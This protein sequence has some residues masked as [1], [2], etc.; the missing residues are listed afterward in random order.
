MDEWMDRQMDQTDGHRGR[1]IW[2]YILSFIKYLIGIF[3][4]LRKIPST[5]V[6]KKLYF[7]GSFFWWEGKEILTKGLLMVEMWKRKAGSWI[8]LLVST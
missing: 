5:N 8:L 7:G 3:S 4:D 2:F 6:G 1:H